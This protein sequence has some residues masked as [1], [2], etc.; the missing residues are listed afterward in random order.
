VE[1]ELGGKGIVVTGGASHIGRAIVHALARE[2]ARIVILDIDGD[3]AGRTAA[4]AL[5]LG[6][7][8]ATV[9]AV[10]LGRHDEA[11]EAT[12]EADQRL[13]GTD[14]LVANV[15]WNEPNFFL[16]YPPEQWSKIVDINLTSC[17]SCVRALLPGMIERQGGTI[18]ATTSGAAFGEPRNSVYAAA[19]A[20]LIA[21]VR[22]IAYEYGRYGIRANCV[23]PGLVL[24]DGTA[25]L[26]AA[27]V[28]HQQRAVVNDVHVQNTLKATPLRRLTKPEDIA[29]SVVFLASQRSRQLT[30]QTL[31]VSG[32][33]KT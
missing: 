30:A 29:D 8:E 19:K 31:I 7:P 12:A 2:R 11:T 32:G 25:E 16:D 1:L 6:A 23:A 22:T 13:G 26:G 21:F 3:Q 28:W 20:G 27:S 10:D 15:G 14:V 4:E 5:E 24:P 33:W 18:V 17:M 9:L